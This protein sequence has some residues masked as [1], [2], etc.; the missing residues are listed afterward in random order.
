M[1]FVAVNFADEF[2]SNTITYDLVANGVAITAQDNCSYV[3][4]ITGDQTFLKGGDGIQIKDLPV[5]ASKILKIRC[6]PF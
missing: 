3:D 2:F 5:H 6:T 1:A 4:V